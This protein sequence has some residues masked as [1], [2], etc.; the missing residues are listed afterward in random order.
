MKIVD[1]IRNQQLL[2]PSDLLDALTEAFPLIERMAETPQEPEWHAEGN[3]RIHTERVIEELYGV[4]ENEGADLAASER[5]ALILGAA[6]HDIGKT[7]TTREEEREGKMRIVSP[8][9]TE[10]GRSFCAPRMPILGLS[11]QEAKTVLSVIGRHHAPKSLVMRNAPTSA[12]WRLSRSIEPRLIYLFELADMRGRD[13]AGGDDS[14]AFEILEL[15]REGAKEAGVWRVT[16]PYADWRERIR[17]L[18]PETALDYVLSEAIRDFE[19][20]R[21]FTPDEAVTRTFEHRENH[22]EVLVTC[23]PSGSGK[24]TWVEK[25][26]ADFERVS[27]DQIR[28]ELT[29]NRADQSKNG[30]V[31]Q[32]AKER[33]RVGLRA[34]KRLVW[35]ATTIR[36]DGRAMV[37]DLA[38][39]YHAATRIVAFGC[40]PDLLLARNRARK[41]PVQSKILERQLDRLQ[42]PEIWEAHEVE[43][44]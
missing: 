44:V 14:E 35:D 22:G 33:L 20:G 4:L 16:D 41:N 1:Q 9:H 29:G 30:E 3:V 5:L 43:M 40:A 23:A 13:V 28:E 12:W 34:K 10:R 25:N 18:V 37:I 2:A 26:C 27:L 19:V 24:S 39:D 31:M 6:L 7:L 32:L 42:W 15:Y 17:G 36:T 11:G 38:H 8:R 21:I